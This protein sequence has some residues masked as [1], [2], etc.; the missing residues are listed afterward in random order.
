MARYA[1]LPVVSID[2][3][4]E[5][6]LVQVA[7]QRVY[8]ASNQTLN[9]FSSGNPLAALIEGQAFAQGEFLFWANQLPQSILAEWIGPFLGA[10]RRIG[11]P[12]SAQLFV[13]ITPSDNTVTIPAG[14]IF[15]SAPNQAD[16]QAYSYVTTDDVNIPSGQ[17]TIAFPVYSQYVGTQYNVPANSITVSPATGINFVG[18]TNP[19]PAVGGSDAETWQEVQERFFP[20]IRRKNPVSAQDWQDLFIDLFGTGTLTS[21]QPNRPSERAYNYL[22][23]YLLPNGQVSFFVL[24]PGGVELT[25]DQLA[26]GQNVVNFSVP[27]E[28]QG[29]LYP[30]TLSQVQFDLTVEVDANG[31]YGGNGRTSSLNFRNRLSD[32]LRPGNIFPPTINPTVSDVDSAFYATFTDTERYINPKIVSSRAYNTPS[33]FDVSAATYTQVYN[34]QPTGDLYNLND[35]VFTTN[36]VPVYYPVVSGFTPYSADKRK[37]TIYGNLVL[38]QIQLL[39]AQTYLQGDIVYWA[40]G[41][42]ADGQL[43]VINQNLT[44][45]SQDDVERLIAEGQISDAKTY[46]A[47]V[48]ND[49]YVNTINGFFNPDIVE[50]DYLPTEFVPD[51]SSPIPLNKRPGAFAWLVGNNFTLQPST[52]DLTGAATAGVLGP[53]LTSSQ[54]QEL[55]PGT[56]YSAGIWVYTPQVGSGPSPVADP[57]FNYVDITK[58]VVN[59]FAYVIQAFTYKPESTQTVSEFFDSAVSQGIIQEVVASNA[60]NG[61]QI[62]KYKPR[63][64]MGAYL[65]YKA[66]ASQASSYYIA[67]E[68][69]TPNST[70]VG[71]LVNEGLVYPLATTPGQNVQLAAYLASGAGII[72]ARMFTFFLGDRTYFRQGSTI[73]SY[74][75][76]SAVTPLFDFSIYLENGVFVLS[77]EFPTVYFETTNYIPFFNT[78]Y[79]NYAEDTIISEDGRNYYRVMK[80]FTPPATV[81]NW[82]NAEVLNTARIEEYEGNLLRYVNF[83]SCEQEILPQLGTLISALKLG[84]AQITLI[85]RN[86]GRFAD[87]SQESIFVWENTASYT[88]TPQLSWFSGTIY[89]YNPPNYRNGTLRL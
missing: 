21:V 56:S 47:W 26:Q 74:T 78:N 5:A 8:D 84:I 20:I 9:D 27:V 12:A 25:V 72:P 48:T 15:T 79:V 17:T 28:N 87:A 45:V 65:E 31:A 2:P 19:L 69:F 37:Q 51:A 57:Y 4:N 62:Y 34:F 61:L 88:A 63:F 39:V 38:K 10:Q 42:N 82:T 70:N 3:R 24:G 43:H 35:L 33:G 68:Y 41:T 11:S 23:D 71:E 44:V 40:T 77:E 14:T 32:I 54:L 18:V 60:D 46:S 50:Y 13:T 22:T 30:I 85:P 16:G 58:G 52:D 64:E 81:V 75:A 76:T 66:D 89:P 67:A 86:N 1:P 55:I 6:D 59:K 53:S 29:H 80:A 73:L 49:S 7:S 36:P 83:Y